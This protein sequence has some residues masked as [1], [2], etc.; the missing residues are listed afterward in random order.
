LTIW[1]AIAPIQQPNLIDLIIQPR[2]TWIES[3]Q[4]EII[5]FLRNFLFEKIEAIN[6]WRNASNILDKEIKNMILQPKG[7]YY[8]LSHG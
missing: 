5:T 1:H 3:E 2:L 4:R 8:H 6:Q 7:L